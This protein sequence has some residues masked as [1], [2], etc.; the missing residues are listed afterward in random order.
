MKNK[1]KWIVLGFLLLIVIVLTFM[2]TPEEIIKGLG[3]ISGEVKF[4]SAFVHILFLV[5]IGLGLLFRQL[6]R[7]NRRYDAPN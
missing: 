5:V 4:Y 7:E 3:Y 2:R 6:P 1:I